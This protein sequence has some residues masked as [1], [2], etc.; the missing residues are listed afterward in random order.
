MV[1]LVAGRNNPKT[2]RMR[3]ARPLVFAMFLCWNAMPTKQYDMGGKRVTVRRVAQCS[4]R[5]SLAVSV[6]DVQLGV[7]NGSQTVAGHVAFRKDTGT[8]LFIRI[9]LRKCDAS[10]APDTCEYVIKDYEAANA[11]DIIGMEKEIWSPFVDNSNMPKE[12][13]IKAGNYT[14][15]KTVITDDLIS[16]VP[17][18]SA[19]WKLRF[20]GFDQALNILCVELEV[21]VKLT[22]AGKTKGRRP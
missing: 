5:R 4:D 12:C 19:V 15:N 18:A 9:D 11:C 16:S 13:P 17:H 21:A 14:L 6:E 3:T 8:K 2:G 22:H 10:G 20:T 7:E 1:S